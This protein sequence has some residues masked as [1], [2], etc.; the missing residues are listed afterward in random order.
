MNIQVVIDFRAILENE[1]S[2]AE[3]Y[4]RLV[5][6]PDFMDGLIELLVEGSTRMNSWPT[7]HYLATMRERLL[8][9]FGAITQSQLVNREQYAESERSKAMS[10]V[11]EMERRI[12]DLERLVK[13]ANLVFEDLPKTDDGPVT[14]IKFA[15]QHR[16]DE[17]CACDACK[18]I[19]YLRKAEVPE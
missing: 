15:V 7:D 13:N 17:S 10:K 9:G 14:C 19:R 11:W 1:K 3:I 4:D 8:T 5:C 18:L 2:K 12:K 16:G 6:E